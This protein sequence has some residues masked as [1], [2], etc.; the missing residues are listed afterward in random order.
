MLIKSGLMKNT[1]DARRRRFL[2][3]AALAGAGTVVAGATTLAD[4]ND[5]AKAQ[6]SPIPIGGITPLT[7]PGAPSGAEAKRGLE[8][9]CEEVNAM[10]GILGRPVEPF[11]GDSK[12]RSADEVV[13]AANLLIDRQEVHAIINGHN[14]GSNNAEYDLVADASVMYIHTNTLRQHDEWIENN[15]GKYP[16]IFMSDP[17]EFWYGPGWIKFISWLRDTGQWTPQNN[18]IALGFGLA[19]LQHRD[20][21]TPP[22]RSRR[23]TDGRSPG[24]ALRRWRR[25]PRSGGR[26]SPRSGRPTRRRSRTRTSMRA[27]LRSS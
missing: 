9:A 21:P 13:S 12:N 22:P 26:S 20:L 7:G 10:G 16:T 8:M 15:P 17:A 23:I 25:R 24:A 6:G 19:S 4:I 5:G 14:I 3:G 2:K 11:F 27:T 18:T 1:V